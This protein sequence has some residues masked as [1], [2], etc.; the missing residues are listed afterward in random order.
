MARVNKD[1]KFQMYISE[2]MENR[3][4]YYADLQG[5]SKSEFVR[6][7]IA[8]VLQGYASGEDLLK[9]IVDKYGI[10]EFMKLAQAKEG[11]A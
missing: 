1:I 5:I 2:K 11:E 6:N 10:E 8:Q 7:C 9:G 4:E 3:I